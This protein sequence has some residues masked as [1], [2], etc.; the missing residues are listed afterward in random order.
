MSKYYYFE[1]KGI[2]TDPKMG[3]ED[4]RETWK[5][6][7]KMGF[8]GTLSDFFVRELAKKGV[9]LRK[10]PKNPRYYL[11]EDFKVVYPEDWDCPDLGKM[12]PNCLGSSV[13]MAEFYGK[14]KPAMEKWFL[15][16]EKPDGNPVMIMSTGVEGMG[17]YGC[18]YELKPGKMSFANARNPKKEKKK[19][20][21]W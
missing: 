16:K 21:N 17:L 8:N 3:G 4:K 1:A 5:M 14:M 18:L 11:E 20:F 19:L 12:K 6:G 9:T 7:F 13:G 2:G 10:N 15:E